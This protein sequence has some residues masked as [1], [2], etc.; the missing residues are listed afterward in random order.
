MVAVGFL[1]DLL[2]VALAEACYP[3]T[4]DSSFPSFSGNGLIFP[5][6]D[7]EGPKYTV[8]CPVPGTA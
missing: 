5:I 7:L 2:R 6:L 8:H 3:C 4:H 1:P